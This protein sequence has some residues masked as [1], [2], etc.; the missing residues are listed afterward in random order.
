MGMLTAAWLV[1]STLNCT[2]CTTAEQATAYADLAPVPHQPGTSV[3]GRGGIGRAGNG[4][5][6]TALYLATLS[7]ARHNPAIKPF[8]D[9][10]RA[11]GK[12]VKVARCAAAQTSPHEAGSS[13]ILVK[14]GPK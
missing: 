7:A 10:L 13:A 3:R 4:R 5:L 11:V 6:R 9:R 2:R 8:S 12:P 1:I 14:R